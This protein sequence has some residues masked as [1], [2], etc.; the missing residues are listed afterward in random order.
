MVRQID[1][2]IKKT[3]TRAGKNLK[4]FLNLRYTGHRNTI[5]K[6]AYTCTHLIIHLLHL[7]DTHLN[8]YFVQLSPPGILEIGPQLLLIPF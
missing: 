5:K 3:L 1:Y 7:N 8:S 6:N 2:L 4:F